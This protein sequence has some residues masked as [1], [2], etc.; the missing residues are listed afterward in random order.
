MAALRPIPELPPVTIATCMV[1]HLFI[2]GV[3]VHQRE[4]DC[5]IKASR[6]PRTTYRC[7]SFTCLILLLP[8]VSSGWFNRPRAPRGAANVDRPPRPARHDHR[9]RRRPGVEGRPAGPGVAIDDRHGA[10]P[11]R[12]GGETPRAG[13]PRVRV[14]RRAVPGRVGRPARSP[15]TSSTRPASTRRWASA[16]CCARRSSPSCSCRRVPATSRPRPAPRH[17]ASPSATPPTSWSTRRCAC[18]GCSTDPA[19]PRC[20]R[21]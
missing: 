17:R 11:H 7:S 8:R 13:R 15:G 3:L 1:N 18:C 16:W 19:T 6:P 4:P 21:R 10:G 9:R 5:S 14:R 2:R 12:A 20:S